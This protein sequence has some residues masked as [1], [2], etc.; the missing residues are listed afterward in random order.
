MRLQELSSLVERVGFLPLLVLFLLNDLVE[1]L[2]SALLFDA[3]S[4]LLLDLLEV[5]LLVFEVGLSLI[6]LLVFLTHL[7]IVG[8]KSARV[9][10][11][12]VLVARQ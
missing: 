6:A 12:G 4:P 5:L 10:L 11:V 9:L 1:V 2:T 7:C 8:L 3:L